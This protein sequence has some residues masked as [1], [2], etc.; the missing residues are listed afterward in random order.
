MEDALTRPISLRRSTH[1]QS[2]INDFLFLA[3]ATRALF[4]L[5]EDY[6]T[7]F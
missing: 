5:R 3:V 7:G 6:F 4:N 2:D 1:V